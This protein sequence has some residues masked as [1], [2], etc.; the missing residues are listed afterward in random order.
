[1]DHFWPRYCKID[2]YQPILTYFNLFEQIMVTNIK[3][4]R[5]A[6]ITFG[7]YWQFLEK[8][9]HILTIS[10]RLWPVLTNLNNLIQLQLLFGYILTII[11]W[12]WHIWTNVFT[13]LNNFEQIWPILTNNVQFWPPVP[14]ISSSTKMS[15][16]RPEEG[17]VRPQTHESILNG[18]TFSTANLLFSITPNHDLL[19]Y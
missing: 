5:R 15:K 18:L 12:F 17:G 11:E 8:F 13:F 14:K 1:M 9:W 19:H 16:L 10:N 6:V 3:R 7:N 4:F 2:Q